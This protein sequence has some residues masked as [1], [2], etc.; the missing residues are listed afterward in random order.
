M[1]ENLDSSQVP[2]D[3]SEVTSSKIKLLVLA[4]ILCLLTC[5]CVTSAVA[6]GSYYYHKRDNSNEDQENLDEDKNTVSEIE[7]NQSDKE[8]DRDPMDD[9]PEIDEVFEVMSNLESY[10][11]TVEMSSDSGSMYAEYRAPNKEYVKG[12]EGA[13]V[14]EEIVIGDDIYYRENQG[15]WSKKDTISLAGFHTELID[16][17]S[18]NEIFE[19]LK[20]GTKND[21]WHYEASDAFGTLEI[22]VDK[23]TSY[24]FKIL[25]LED[26]T[27]IGEYM[28]GDFNSEDI[29]IEAPI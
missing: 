12:I 27:I 13:S 9:Q 14:T 18:W 5:C 10:S 11:I 25:M 21:Y 1:E 2:T 20:N 29:N 8:E 17:D 16:A 6:G 24:M 3:N 23:K 7:N 4:I 19:I 22:Y 15:A 28:F 26:D